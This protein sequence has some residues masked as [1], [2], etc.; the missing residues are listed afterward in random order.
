MSESALSEVSD[1]TLPSFNDV[2]YI[3]IKGKGHRIREY[4]INVLQRIFTYWHGLY[5]LNQLGA[6]KGGHAYGETGMYQTLEAPFLLASVCREFKIAM[7]ESPELW[8]LVYVNFASSNQRLI[9]R[10]GQLLY[11]SK[12]EPLTIVF[13]DINI[14]AFGTQ[15]FHD[16]RKILEPIKSRWVTVA[17][18]FMTPR[19][20][21][22]C[23]KV[24]SLDGRNVTDLRLWG[25]VDG[26]A[27]PIPRGFLNNSPAVTSL[28][29]R[30]IAWIHHNGHLP[31]RNVTR[32]CVGPSVDE[33]LGHTT[34][35]ALCASFPAVKRLKLLAFET[36]LWTRHAEQ[37]PAGFQLGQLTHLTVSPVMLATSLQGFEAR[38]V[39]P[40]LMSV[41][42]R[43]R[44][45]DEE[46][47]GD[48]EL[49]ERTRRDQDL[50]AAGMFLRPHAIRTLKL[51]GL[52]AGYK[53]SAVRTLVFENMMTK[54]L[55]N[56]YLEEC[57]HRTT[58]YV[59]M[60]LKRLSFRAMSPEG[61]GG[62]SVSRAGSV[63]GEGL[64]LLPG[65]QYLH[66]FKCEDLNV[67]ELPQWV[68][69]APRGLKDVVIRSSEVTAE[70]KYEEAKVF[71]KERM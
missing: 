15:W 43:F 41:S 64:H 23:W 34:V 17:A 24:W 56:L 19:D 45:T 32:L 37:L 16:M 13:K 30:N 29:L 27:S 35:K 50:A 67:A 65:L 71:L 26:G 22:A 40:A 54:E 48:E 21:E 11:L 52:D 59:E 28:E 49:E 36:S 55:A 9:N 47:E 6:V 3:D 38:H 69:N 7:E 70:D 68:K 58:R 44:Q 51:R 62:R 10:L 31:M 14:T 1:Y 4:P 46:L 12:G 66:V 8:T 18:S 42:I 63:N 57:S 53:P 25:S 20:L 60:A 61:T 33:V 39:L 5:A 2:P